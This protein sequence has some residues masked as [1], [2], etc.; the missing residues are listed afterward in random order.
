MTSFH[1]Q[2]GMLAVKLHGP[3]GNIQGAM[4]QQFS[5]YYPSH[6]LAQNQSIWT[7]VKLMWWGLKGWTSDS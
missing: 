4:M 1:D 6:L 5:V 2:N 7:Y 3:Y